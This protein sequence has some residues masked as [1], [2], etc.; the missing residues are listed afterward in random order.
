MIAPIIYDT[1]GNEITDCKQKWFYNETTGT[2][3]QAIE[4]I[5]K[6][7]NHNTITHLAKVV[8][9]RIEDFIDINNPLKCGYNTKDELHQKIAEYFA[10]Q[11]TQYVNRRNKFLQS[12]NNNML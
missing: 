9:H 11:I 1:M 8:D 7:E 10:T 5:A 3:E 2:I 6:I 12:L 4:G